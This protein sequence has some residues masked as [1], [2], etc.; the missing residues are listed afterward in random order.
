MAYTEVVLF[1]GKLRGLRLAEN[2]H[3]LFGRHQV[4]HLITE[5]ISATSAVIGSPIYCARPSFA[6]FIGQLTVAKAAV[7]FY[8]LGG[9]VLVAEVFA[10]TIHYFLPNLRIIG[11]SP[12]LHHVLEQAERVASLD[13]TIL[14][15]GESGTG[16]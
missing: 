11:T 13:T 9:I 2:Q 16:K 8:V 6:T 5:K 4:F 7:A 3:T 1:L 10:P 15:C 12:A 14:L